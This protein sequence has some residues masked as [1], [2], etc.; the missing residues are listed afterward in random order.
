MGGG[1]HWSPWISRHS[2]LLRDA[3]EQVDACPPKGCSG[4]VKAPCREVLVPTLGAEGVAPLCV[5]A[6]GRTLG[7]VTQWAVG[8]LSLLYSQRTDRWTL[9]AIWLQAGISQ[10]LLGWGSQTS[11]RKSPWWSR[12]CLLGHLCLPLTLADRF[13]CSSSSA[14]RWL[15]RLLSTTAPVW[16]AGSE[17][18]AAQVTVICITFPEGLWGSFDPDG[19]PWKI[20]F[21]V[22]L[23]YCNKINYIL[24][25][26]IIYNI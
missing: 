14:P 21:D 12:L 19:F 2:H 9:L 11:Y 26:I 6:W 5:S 7:V 8:V 17:S 23:K 18:L 3:V 24:S 25:S 10:A 15:S 22:S 16:C 13:L 4:P 20:L 1:Y